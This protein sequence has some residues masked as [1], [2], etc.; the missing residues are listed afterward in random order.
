MKLNPDCIRDILLAVEDTSSYG[1][2]ISSFELYKSTSLSN[3]SENEILYHVRQLAWS[4]MLE[5]TDFYLDNSFS[6]LDLSPQGHEF[7]NNIRS[8]DNWNKTKEFS[9]KIGSLAVST[10]QSVASS[11]ISISIQKYLGL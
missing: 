2:I 1:K 3:Y 10:L 5:Q 11:I 4:K 7:L 9:A 8:D 6:I